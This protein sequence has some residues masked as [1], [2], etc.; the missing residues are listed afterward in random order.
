MRFMWNNDAREDEQEKLSN[1]LSD[2]ARVKKF[3]SMI[4]KIIPPLYSECIL[5]ATVLKILG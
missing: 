4:E 3:L 1:A 2:R 5:N